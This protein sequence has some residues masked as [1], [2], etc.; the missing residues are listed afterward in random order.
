MTQKIDKKSLEKAKKI[1]ETKEV[2]N[3]EVWTLAW[4]LEIHK[5]LFDWLY[6]FAWKIRS[7]NISKWNFRFANV[8]YLAEILEKIEKMPENSFEE[9]V[10]K[11]VE[12]NIA[13]PFLEWN[14]RTMRIW[15]DMMFRKN[16]KKVVNWEKIDKDLYLQAM[17]RSPVNDLEI[18][19]L[20]EKNLTSEIDNREVIFKWIE[21][22]YFYEWYKE[23]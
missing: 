21:Q 23:F 10:E 16:L 12:M 13:H 7:Q 11:Y 17:E 3:I 22:S 18:R 6:D 2:Y 4:L 15:L 14:W 20:L 1:F 5:K 9:I 8:L 19:F